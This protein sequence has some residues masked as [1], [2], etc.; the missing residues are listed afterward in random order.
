[1]V[2]TKQREKKLI[3]NTIILGIGTVIPKLSSFIIL[4]ILTAYLTKSEYGTYD[5]IVILAS[6]LLPAVTLQLQ[7]AGFRFLIK[8]N[9]DENKKRKIISN[10]LLFIIPTSL[11]VLVFLFF[12]LYKYSLIDR[13][14]IGIY[15]LGDILYSTFGQISRGQSKNKTYA[16]GSII[17]SIVNM[18]LTVV[19]IYVFRMGLTGV[20]IS[21]CLSTV[22][23]TLFLGY[24]TSIFKYF[25]IGLFDKKI[26]KELL[27]YSWPM[28]PNS[29]SMWIMNTSDR[30]IIIG[31]PGLGIEANAIYAVAKK[32]P[33][34]LTIVQ[35]TFTMAWQESA[36]IASD[37]ND[38]SEYYTKM[39]DTVFCFMSMAYIVLLISMPILFKI[40]IKGDYSDSYN[41]MPIIIAGM[42][43]FSV[44]SFLGG[45]YVAKMKTKSVGITTFIAAIINLITCLL[46]I[47]KIGI[48]AASIST[49]VSYVFLSIYRMIDV[50]KIIK[51][52]YNLKK[53][54]LILLILIII[55]LFSYFKNIYI[56][57]T[58]SIASL[59]AAYII[60]K[61][62]ICAIINNLKEKIK[63]KVKRKK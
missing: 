3:L 42:F 17:Y 60:N 23:P 28:V 31:T 12:I 22:I 27:K 57:I 62:M 37:D 48:Y 21:L 16:M 2:D 7:T 5:L 32:I 29:L 30:L 15:F 4:P 19:L 44:S 1:M 25:R 43:F 26:L 45:I 8:C 46:L 63:K 52:K 36:S 56:Y 10:I 33:N 14:L 40:L 54:L 49:L 18:I 13:T 55:S 24:K 35:S 53:I 41:Q 38:A 6:L 47:R 51:V 39:F 58:Y 59:I 61:N 50:N 11:I 9:D 34:I 20:L